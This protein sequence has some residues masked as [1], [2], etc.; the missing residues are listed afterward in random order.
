MSRIYAIESVFTEIGA[1]ADHRLALRS[2]LIKAVAAYLDAEVSKR[3]QP[4]PEHGPA[5]PAPDAGF[6]RDAGAKKFLGIVAQELLSHTGR[7]LVVTGAHQPPEVHALVH[8]LNVLLGNA[9]RTVRYV[10]SEDFDETPGVEKLNGLVEAM[11]GGGVETLLMLGGNPV[12][13][14]PADIP[15]AAALGKVKTTVHLSLYEDE[16]SMASTWH[17]PMAHYLEAWSDARAF[18]GSIRVG[19]PL[20]KP[21]FDG[22]TGAELLTRLTA[23]EVA[24][25][26]SIVKESLS[27][28]APTEKSWRKAVHDGRIEAT[29]FDSASPK[30]R[31]IGQ[32]SFEP[33][34]LGG[35]EAGAWGSAPCFSARPMWASW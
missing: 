22:L 29:A 25:S 17:V 30:L 20:I 33:E 16:T 13:S 11:N 28:Y 5:Q 8:R 32:L 4:L 7:S 23:D 34:E 31:A 27:K 24:T 1:L 26:A 3:A 21:L 15:F 14:V 2:G 6:L 18:D 12:Y 9:G 35:V 10:Q 19:Q